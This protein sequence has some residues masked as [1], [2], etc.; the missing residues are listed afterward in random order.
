MYFIFE[1][2]FRDKCGKKLIH[3]LSVYLKQKTNNPHITFSELYNQT[4]KKSVIYGT[5]LNTQSEKNIFSRNISRYDCF[6]S[7]QNI[8][9]YSIILYNV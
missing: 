2:I 7:C 8:Y 9:Q 6:R 3:F 5:C 1:K 4:Q